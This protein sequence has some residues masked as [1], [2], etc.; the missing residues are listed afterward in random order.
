[1][2]I[3][4]V[5]DKTGPLAGVSIVTEDQD[6]LMITNDGTMIR[7]A[8]DGISV[9]GRA[10]G[11]VKVITPSEGAKVASVTVIADEE[12]LGDA[13][14]EGTPAEGNDTEAVEV[15]EE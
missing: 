9:Q 12:K 2:I 5:T 11:G 3:Q 6:I 7:T 10:A 14:A 13:P 4:N 1:M 8:A 15:K